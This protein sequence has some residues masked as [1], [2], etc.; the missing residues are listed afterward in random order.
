MSDRE[1]DEETRRQRAHLKELEDHVTQEER[2]REAKRQK[3]K[4]EKE[5]AAELK[6]QQ[7]EKE[8]GKRGSN[9]SGTSKELD[10]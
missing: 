4:E 6:R 7:R 3:Y 2:E 5:K 9:I 8:K 1:L 10:N